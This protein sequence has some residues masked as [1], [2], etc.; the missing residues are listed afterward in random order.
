MANSP[1]E[2][3]RAGR[4]RVACFAPRYLPVPTLPSVVHLLK[5]TA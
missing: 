2:S 3:D 1:A 5:S 4:R